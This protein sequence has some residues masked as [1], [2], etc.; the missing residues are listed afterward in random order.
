MLTADNSIGKMENTV[1]STSQ[2]KAFFKRNEGTLKLRKKIYN[3][4]RAK[5][6]GY[7]ASRCGSPYIPVALPSSSKVLFPQHRKWM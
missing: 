3:V 6:R 2:R 5:W 7:T 4:F 1:N